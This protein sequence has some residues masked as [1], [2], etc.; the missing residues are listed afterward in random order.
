MKKLAVTILATALTGCATYNPVAPDY[1]GPTAV[2]RDT[3]FNE[4]STKAQI[5]AVTA[6]DGNRIGNAFAGT[7]MASQGHGALITAVYPERKV[8][9]QQ[10]KL[11]LRGSHATGAPIQALASQM[12]GTFFSVEDT[13]DFL[14]EA[15]HVYLVK[16]D[17]KKE[18]SSVWIEDAAT[19]KPVTPIVSK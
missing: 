6:V 3:G 17:L 12:A 16:G 18:K 15:D 8:P 1:K 14:P 19:G 4:D 5:F 13:V 9:V 7:A 10:M 11:T 2:I